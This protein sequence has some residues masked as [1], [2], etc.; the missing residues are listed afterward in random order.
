MEV[1]SWDSFPGSVPYSPFPSSASAFPGKQEQSFLALLKARQEVME[2]IVVQWQPK[3][4]TTFVKCFSRKFFHTCYFIWPSSFPFKPNVLVQHFSMVWSFT[5]TRYG[6]STFYPEQLCYGVHPHAG[7][8]ENKI[9][10]SWP[11]HLLALGVH[12]CP[13]SSP[14]LFPP[15]LSRTNDA[16]PTSPIALKRIQWDKTGKSISSC[17][18]IASFWKWSV[19]LSD[20]ECL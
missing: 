15:V 1:G 19:C 14:G 17:G 5:G 13:S 8:K 9:C 12:L 10:N 3:C 2:C 18:V 4:D 7:K 20:T 11:C 16:C 6:P